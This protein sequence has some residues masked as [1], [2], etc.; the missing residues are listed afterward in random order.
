MV[1]SVFKHSVCYIII[2]ASVNFTKFTVFFVYAYQGLALLRLVLFLLA[3]IFF[4]ELRM[5]NCGFE[6]RV[7]VTIW[8]IDSVV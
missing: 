3:G 7:Y 6:K 8:T 1:A 4:T 5:F 2:L